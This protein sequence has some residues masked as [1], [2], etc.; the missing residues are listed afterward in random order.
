MYDLNTVIFLFFSESKF[1]TKFMKLKMWNLY[2]QISC[3]F[4]EKNQLVKM[5]EDNV[6]ISVIF[7]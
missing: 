2:F 7:Y 5:E 4:L 1:G 3:K 6:V